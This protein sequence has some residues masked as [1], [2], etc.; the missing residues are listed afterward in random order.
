MGRVN[1]GNEMTYNELEDFL[2]AAGTNEIE[3]TGGRSLYNHLTNVYSILKKFG[4]EEPLCKAGLFHSIYGNAIFTHKTIHMNDE[5]RKT[6][7]NLIGEDAEKIVKTFCVAP[8]HRRGYFMGMDPCALRTD[9]I[10]LFFVNAVEQRPIRDA[11]F[12]EYF[13]GK[14]NKDLYE[15]FLNKSEYVDCWGEDAT[16]RIQIFDGKVDDA[17]RERVWN[18]LDAD[19]WHYGHKSNGREDRFCFWN[20]NFV[21]EKHITIPDDEMI[22]FQNDWPAINELWNVIF[23]E[24]SNDKFRLNNFYRAYANGYTYGTGGSIH[25]DD[26]EWTILYYPNIHWEP[27]WLGS[28][29]FY[30]IDKSEVIK[31]SAYVPGRFVLLDAK[32]PHIANAVARECAELRTIITFKC[33]RDFND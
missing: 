6:V 13:K 30:S 15:H 29:S 1:K 20:K 27:E 28:T 8:E 5:G 19:I 2:L 21:G 31:T 12:F 3:H 22:T 10:T 9:L 17:L 26:G 7:R 14:I 24:I 33:Y 16:D 18:T 32:I 11:S 23:K 25:T 4:C